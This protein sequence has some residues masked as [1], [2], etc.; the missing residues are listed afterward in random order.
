MKNIK[1]AIGTAAL[2]GTLILGNTVPAFAVTPQYTSWVPKIPTITSSDLPDSAKDDINQMVSNSFNNWQDSQKTTIGKTTVSEAVF[3]HYKSIWDKARLQVRWSLVNG[4]KS[5]EVK[6]TK[7]DGSS[8]TYTTTSTSLI[9][10]QDSDSFLM[11]C[12][13]SGKVTVRAVGSDGTYGDW[14]TAK[15]ISCNSLH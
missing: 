5:Y 4:A 8:K 2:V 12:V 9:V 15:T 6:V 1:R 10:Y 13:K 14:S 7:T 3:R 11:D